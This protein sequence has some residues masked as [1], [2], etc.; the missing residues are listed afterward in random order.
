[1]S[2]SSS[3]PP[4]PLYTPPTSPKIQ[5]RR[6]ICTKCNRPLKNACLCDALP[7]SKI[8]LKT[9]EILMLQHPFEKKRPMATVP[10][11]HH[12][13]ETNASN[14]TL[15]I[16]KKISQNNETINKILA[17][18]DPEQVLV[19]FPTEKPEIHDPDE[20]TTSLKTRL[21]IVLDGTW[22]QAKCLYRESPILHQFK[23]TPGFYLKCP[24]KRTKNKRPGLRSDFFARVPEIIFYD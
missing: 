17:K 11:L 13:I 6:E 21:L 16:C 9:T 18:Y 15:H 24:Y 5:K 2:S 12:I 19:L 4:S 1:M 10:L 7:T 14:Y 8:A 22:R 3:E 23:D 20:P